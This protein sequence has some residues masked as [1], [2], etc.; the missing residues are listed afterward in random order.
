[1]SKVETFVIYQGPSLLDGQEIVVLAQTGSRNSKTGAMVQTFILRTDMDPIT[2]NR[3]GADVSICGN[4]PLRGKAHDG[5]KGTAKERACYVTL[6]H[7][8]LIKYKAWKR[9]IYPTATGHAAIKAIGAGLMVR[10]GTY[11]DGAAVPSYIWDSLCEDAKGWTAY[12]HQNGMKGAATDPQRYMTSAESSTDA[13]AAWLRGER[14]FRVIR[15]VADMVKGREIL[16]PASE[17]AGRRVTCIDC[18]LCAGAA[19]KAKSI[20]IVAHGGAKRTAKALVAA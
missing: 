19:K 17:E 12:T 13:K 5:P 3:T 15:D 9:G 16:C 6:A 20:A 8:P 1:M 10:I 2:A 4:C 14:T 18:G 7:G 11:G